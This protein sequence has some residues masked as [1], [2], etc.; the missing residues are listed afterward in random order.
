ML[1]AL[2]IAIV[3]VIGVEVA[4]YLAG[5]IQALPKAQ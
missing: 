4:K 2:F 5:A 3:T 1:K